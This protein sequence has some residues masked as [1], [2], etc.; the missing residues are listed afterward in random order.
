MKMK[1]MHGDCLKRMFNIPDNSID[2]VCC[3]LPYGKTKHKWDTPLDLG[4]LWKH[5]KRIVKDNGAICLFGSQPFTSTLVMSNFKMFRYEW[6]WEKDKPNNFALANKQPMKYHENIL[7][8]YKRQPVYNKQL[9]ARTGSGKARYK[10]VVDNRKQTSKHFT[11]SE[12]PKFFDPNLKNPSTIQYFST[13]RRQDLKHPQKPVALIRYLI[14][15]YTNTRDMVLDNCMG[16][17]TTGVA[18]KNLNRNFIGIERDRKW[19]KLAKS[20]IK[21]AQRL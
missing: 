3:D 20:I 9:Q 8:F 5:Y 21:E 2:M 12:Q 6:I 4:L 15:T 19:F 17:G 14:K 7:I 18:C 16:S 10:Y 13:G 11:L 1:L